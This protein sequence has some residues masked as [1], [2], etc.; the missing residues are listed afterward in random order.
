MT[1]TGVLSRRLT[2]LIALVAGAL[3]LAACSFDTLEPEPTA[4]PTAV[5]FEPGDVAV[6]TL[7][8]D[9]RASWES[10]D[11]WVAETRGDS[12]A[13]EGDSGISSSTTE[14][15]VRPDRRRILTMNGDTV[16]TEEIVLDGRIYMRGTLVSSSIYPAAGPEEWISFTADQ[17]PEGSVLEQEVAFLTAPPEYPFTS[18]TAET[19]A[20]PAKP[21]GEVRVGDRTCDAWRFTTTTPETAGIDYTIAF[22][23]ENRPCQLVREAGGVVETTTWT[24]PAE[25]EPIEAPQDATPVA[26]FPDQLP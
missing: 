12:T 14:T 18:I 23:A 3:L 24:Y 1:R 4:T 10:V 15:V 5:A 25:P 2:T 7:I 11:A 13:T 22:D 19:R 26:A 8:D 21:S 16:V 9:A 6:G 20:L 17:V